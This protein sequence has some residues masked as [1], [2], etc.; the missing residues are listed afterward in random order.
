[1][2]RYGLNLVY[3]PYS[4]E[5]ATEERAIISHNGTLQPT[6]S[7]MDV[8]DVADTKNEPAFTLQAADPDLLRAPTEEELRRYASFIHM[9]GG[10]TVSSTAP[11]TEVY[12]PEAMERRKQVNPAV[13]PDWRP[14]IL[15][16]HK[17]EPE[18]F[19]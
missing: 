3:R 17:L 19:R 10:L 14:Q 12:T 2:S 8:D 15:V 9:W 11:D 4:L 16:W 1:M 5:L 13:A 6:T 18:M 7:V